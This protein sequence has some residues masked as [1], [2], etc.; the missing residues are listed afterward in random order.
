MH[1]TQARIE[2]LVRLRFGVSID[3]I[4][5][6]EPGLGSRRFFRVRL[7][8]TRAA[9]TSHPKAVPPTVV[10]RVEA[11]EDAALRPASVAPEPALEPLRSLLE[12]SGLPVPASYA[13]E[14]GLSLLEDVGDTS[15]EAAAAELS[16]AALSELYREA[17]EHL[18]RLQRIEDPG[19][20]AA[21]QRRLDAALYRY[22]AEQFIE[23]VLP[24]A[25]ANTRRRVGSSASDGATTV[26][27]DAFG[28]IAEHC[29]SAPARLAHRDY[30]AAN[31]HLRP[32]I[33]S[34][35]R[36]VWIDLQGAFLA[37]PE[38]D[39]VCLLRDS[40]VELPEPLVQKLLGEIR[41]KLPDMPDPQ[42]FERRF[43][44]L[45][46]TRN[47]KDLARY[48][49]AAQVRNDERYLPL[50]PRAVRTL[51]AAASL[52]AGWDPSLAR[53]GE[54]LASLPENPCAQ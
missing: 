18:P 42:S 28:W 47:G 12:A 15:L 5:A 17:C 30:K 31:L 49:Y 7:G 23:W 4:V 27:R 33:T 44:L 36:L 40:H 52:A 50:V 51:Q 29:G 45:T 22:K 24:W 41:G 20:L 38:Y 16:P 3:E 21:F 25:R 39:L 37:P 34:G 54:L 48:L 13:V 19:D 2:A 8:G 26:V 35:P 14:A 46:L 10:A 43:T 32:G 6:I 9:P 11:A 1:E 53:L